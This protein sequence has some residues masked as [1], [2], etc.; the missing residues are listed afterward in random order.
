MS[1]EQSR[2]KRQR[3]AT[4]GFALALLRGKDNP[5]LRIWSAIFAV[6]WA[7]VIWL[8][9]P[10]SLGIAVWEN[11]IRYLGLALLL[12]VTF[13]AYKLLRNL[14]RIVWHLGLRWLC[15]ILLAL[16]AGATFA[17]GRALG[18]S[19]WPGWQSVAGEVATGAINRV[20]HFIFGLV[21][22]PSDVYMAATG[23]APFWR[24]EPAAYGEP[25]VLSQR[26][27]EEQLV[28]PSEQDPNGITRGVIA[29]A[30]SDDG[31]VINLRADPG[32]EAAIRT[33]LESGTLLFVTGGPERVNEQIW[34]QVSDQNAEGWCSAELL[35]LVSR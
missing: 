21:A 35:V 34:W 25:S 27:E 14:G 15:A 2:K 3:G 7:A 20:G 6:L 32:T 29:M 17:R 24:P 22:V 16:F 12:L 10:Y 5:R 26:T 31:T 1:D 8:T 23:N 30:V 9:Y 28:L 4:Q 13:A 11:N 33:K 19:D 18:A